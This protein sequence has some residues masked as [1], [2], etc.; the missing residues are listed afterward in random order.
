VRHAQGLATQTTFG[1]LP[2]ESFPAACRR[3]APRH[4]GPLCPGHTAASRPCAA[5]T[6]DQQGDGGDAPQRQ[7]CG[8]RQHLRGQ[9]RRGSVAEPAWQRAE[10][11]QRQH[12]HARSKR[13][14]PAPGGAASA[15]AWEGREGDQV[16]A[17]EKA[18]K[19]PQDVVGIVG[20]P[21][22]VIKWPS[23]GSGCRCFYR[24]AWPFMKHIH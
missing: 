10:C 2:Q 15:P 3:Q 6:C 8:Q 12:L 14:A 20:N 24:G 19:K 11:G 4:P 18:I 13:A 5:P 1:V 9:D 22:Y 23:S 21:L 17:A 7:H 16:A